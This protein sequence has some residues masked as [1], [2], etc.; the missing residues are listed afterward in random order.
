MLF[1]TVRE[2]LRGLLFRNGRLVDLL[3]PGKHRMWNPLVDHDVDFVSVAAGVVEVTPDLDIERVLSPRDG[4]V[5]D[6]P[7][8]HAGLVTRDGRPFAVLRPGRWVLWQVAAV[9]E[10][11]VVDLTGLDTEIPERFR[12]LVPNGLLFDVC[13]HAHE[14]GLLYVDGAFER[15]LAP[16]RHGFS[17]WNRRIRVDRVDMR[18]RELQV[19]GQELVTRDK[20]ALRLNLLARFRVTDPVAATQAVEDLRDALYAEVQLA[21]RTAVAG[22]TLDALLAERESIASGL[23]DS[24]QARAK[25]W[26]VQIARVDVKDVVLPG[27]MKALMNR[28]IE[29][30]KRAAAQVIMRREEVA[31]TR[32]LANTARLLESNPVLLR[33]KEIEA[34]KDIVERIPNLTVVVGGED[35]QGKLRLALNPSGDA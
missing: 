17:P 4:Y 18:E 30:E 10:A 7:S 8:D 12:A 24:V 29:A 9:H 35:L 32:S 27:E 15:V 26:G 33:L 14:R 19:V 31:A 16:G 5:L 2:G 34:Y 23:Q 1:I 22:V 20:A 21:A 3:T 13:V 11:E 25:A 28:V 6:V